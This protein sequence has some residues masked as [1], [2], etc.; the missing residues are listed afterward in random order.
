MKST[1]RVHEVAST[2]SHY[3]QRLAWVIHGSHRAYCL[4]RSEIANEGDEGEALLHA[5]KAQQERREDGNPTAAGICGDGSATVTILLATAVSGP[6][7]AVLAPFVGGVTLLVLVCGPMDLAVGYQ[8][9]NKVPV[10]LQS[11]V[12]PRS[13][14]ARADLCGLSTGMIKFTHRED[15]HPVGSESAVA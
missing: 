1:H 14:P 3:K 10:V 12:N 5:T 7:A 9:R 2:D 4:A 13:H 15:G 11:S 8:N 6:L